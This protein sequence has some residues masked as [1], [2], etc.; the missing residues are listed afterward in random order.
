MDQITI[1][2]Y[3]FG[4]GWMI[5][6]MGDEKTRNSHTCRILITCA[7][8]KIRDTMLASTKKYQ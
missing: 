2:I 7:E 3:L 4:T 5:S 8:E 1:G 6:W